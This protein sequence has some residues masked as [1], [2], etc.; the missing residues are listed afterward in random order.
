MYPT[1][2][3]LA[4][5]PRWR[6]VVCFIRD[7]VGPFDFD[8]GM[9]LKELD[10]ILLAKRLNLP[11]AV[12]EWYRLAANWDQEGLNAWIPPQ[13]LTASDGAVWILTDSAGVN[14][15]G[16]RVA[17]LGAEDPPVFSLVAHEIDFSNFSSFVPAMIVNDVIF[18]YETEAEAPVELNPGA[19][20]EALACLISSAGCGDFYADAPLESATVVMFTYPENGSAFGRARTP[21]GHALLER[22]RLHAV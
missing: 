8:H 11:A 10:E 12:R 18:N 2:S 13:D 22:L 16:I 6:D 17:D 1:W 14:H 9:A 21:T 7:W 20:R 19:A 5:S 15:W 4:K 3:E